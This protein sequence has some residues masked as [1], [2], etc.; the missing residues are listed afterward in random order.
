MVGQALPSRTRC[1]NRTSVWVCVLTCACSA[2]VCVLTCACPHACHARAS[3]SGLPRR[4]EARGPGLWCQPLGRSGG[5]CGLAEWRG[6]V[7][8]VSL[9]A[10]EVSSCCD[11]ARCWVASCALLGL[12]RVGMGT[13]GTRE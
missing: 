7:F 3:L 6:V 2:W 8:W 11:G 10:Q 5:P 9:C 12:E 13:A 4:T 1:L